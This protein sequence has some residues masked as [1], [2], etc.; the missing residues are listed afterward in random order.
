MSRC[1][2]GAWGCTAMVVLALTGC[3]QNGETRAQVTPSPVGAVI[4]KQADGISYVNAGKLL[5]LR[6]GQ[7]E[8]VTTP[9]TVQAVGIGVDAGGLVVL[10]A[11][12]PESLRLSWYSSATGKLSEIPFSATT[13]SLGSVRYL[14]KP[15]SLWFSVYG[16]PDTLLMSATPSDAEAMARA[17][18]SGFNG[19]FDVDSRGETI[20]YVG[21]NQNPSTLTVRD[22][23][24]ESAVPTKLALI[25]SPEFSAD[26]TML[27]FVGG[28]SPEELSIWILDRGTGALRELTETRGLK[29]TMPVFAADGAKLAF[30]GAEDGSLWIVD[31][32]SGKP[33]KL[34]VIADE[35]P[36]GW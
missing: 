31:V 19:E 29:P 27:C 32:A 16:D 5:V 6:D 36:F 11:D 13:G 20:A 12:Q 17:L 33:Q 4:P 7:A 28:Q 15:D 34:P 24:G 9:G 30:R 8:D 18:D 14:N 35:G 3:S 21:N 23:E 2:W 25:F 10:D 1:R 22:G 26:D